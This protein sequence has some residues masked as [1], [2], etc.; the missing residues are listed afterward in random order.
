MVFDPA[1]GRHGRVDR[2]CAPRGPALL[3]AARGTVEFSPVL[4]VYSRVVE[5]LPCLRPHLLR[6]GRPGSILRLRRV[7]CRRRRVAI[8]PLQSVAACRPG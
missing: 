4:G 2:R 6:E 7:V 1:L 8:P 5:C 3:G